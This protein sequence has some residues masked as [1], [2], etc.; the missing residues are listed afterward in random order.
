M[1]ATWRAVAT[2]DLEDAVRS[3]TL[4]SLVALFVAF[5]LTALLSAEQLFPE[6]VTVTPAKALSGVAMLG[7]LFVPG[8]ALVAGYMAVVGERRSGSLRILLSYP[9]SR[10]D[11][12]WG[13]LLGR[14]LVTG[15]ALVAGYAVGSV[16][17]VVLYG[18]P[19][20]TA[21]LGFAGAGLL[22]GAS[23]TGL[24]VGGSAAARTR[25][26]AL[27]ATVG[28][29]VGWVFFWKPA[30]VGLYYLVEGEIPGLRA[31]PWYYLLQRLNPL[32]AFR[33]VSS[34]AL[35]EDVSPV[36]DLPLEDVPR[37]APSERVD[38]AARVA[39]EVPFYLDA[40]VAVLV[41][42]A[43]GLVPVVVGHRR[44]ERSDLD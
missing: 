19:D 16:A 7:G 38:V 41:L 6:P 10:F 44:F 12:V 3:R 20:T 8:I 25:G 29:F 24:A 33:V 42:L 2:K 28:S 32:E 4:W 37:T 34:V 5:L 15:V 40:W 27:A 11:V 35:G 26:Q 13:K 21:F 36:P 14:L 9:F 39:G 17:V 1:S 43:W 18:P 31:E 23:M 22:L 30:V